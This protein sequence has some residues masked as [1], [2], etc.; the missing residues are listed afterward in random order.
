MWVSGSVDGQPL[1]AAI[2]YL[3]S[4]QLRIHASYI[5]EDYFSLSFLTELQDFLIGT[6]ETDTVEVTVLYYMFCH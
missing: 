4:K 1:K 6:M 3:H 2:H 5:S